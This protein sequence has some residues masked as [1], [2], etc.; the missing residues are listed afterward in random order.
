VNVETSG[1]VIANLISAL[2]ASAFLAATSGARAHD[3]KLERAKE[4]LAQR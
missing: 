4:Y 1:E 2:V 3:G